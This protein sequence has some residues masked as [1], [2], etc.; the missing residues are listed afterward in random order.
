M[1]DL[2]SRLDLFIKK[3][4]FSLLVKNIIYFSLLTIS[5]ILFFSFIEY[6]FWL[7]SFFRGV[8][9]FATIL[10]LIFIGIIYF[11]LP[12]INISKY[13]KKINRYKAA[14]IIGSFF[15]EI[16]DKFRNTLEL[17]DI[18]DVSR[19]NIDLLDAAVR[20]KS[21]Q[22]YNININSAIQYKGLRNGAIVLLII[23]SAFCMLT[24]S[25]PEVV[26][27]SFNRIIHYN[28]LYIKP[29]PFQ[30]IL[31]NKQL[32]GVQG[33]EET[34]ELTIDGTVLPDQSSIEINGKL[35]PMKKNKEDEF[36]YTISQ[37]KTSFNFRFYAGGYYSQMYFYRV[38]VRPTIV[39]FSVELLYP[40]YTGRINETL[41][42][43]TDYSVP[44]GTK[45]Q[46]SFHGKNVKTLHVFNED[47]LDSSNEISL[48]KNV[49]RYMKTFYN[50]SGIQFNASNDQIMS[51]DTLFCNVE[52][53][54]DA[55]PIIDVLNIVDSTEVTKMY[56]RGKIADDYGFSAL[57][58]CYKS[59]GENEFIKI[60]VP[61]EK[62]AIE[63]EFFFLF[64]FA[65]IEGWRDK[66]VEYYFLVFDN[67]AVNGNKST[68][69]SISA[70]KLPNKE[71]LDE[72]YQK[73]QDQFLNSMNSSMAQI[74]QFQKEMEQMRYDLLNKKEITWE[75]RNK[76]QNLIQKQAE[77]EKQMEEMG[78]ENYEKNKY[79]ELMREMSP[80]M[81]EKQKQ[82]E[83]LFNDIF[84]EEMKALME[85]M[86]EL[87]Q[88]MNKEKMLD[89]IE[90]MQL[91]TEDIEK[92]LQRNMEI[93]KQLEFEK[94][95]NETLDE[96]NQIK[97]QLDS[98]NAQT[99]NS[100]ANQQDLVQKQQQINEAYK[101]VKEE[102]Q[103][104]Q[105]MNEE[106]F[107]PIDFPDA[108]ELMENIEQDLNEAQNNLTKDKKSQASKNQKSGSDQMKE[109]SDKLNN[110]MQ[111][112]E[113]ESLSEDID[114][115]KRILKNLIHISL[116]QEDNITMAK[117]LGPRD[118]RY[119]RVMANQKKIYTRFE[120]VE[121]SLYALSLRQIMIQP[122]IAKD[123]K[124]IKE[125]AAKIDEYLNIGATI[126][127]MTQQQY[128]M[129]STNNLALL[130]IEALD[131]M[132]EMLSKMQM[133]GQGGQC[134]KPKPG[135]SPGKSPTPKTL[136][137]MQEQLNQQMEALMKQ[138]QGG[139]KSGM[140]GSEISEQLAKLA[141]QQ[142]AIRRQL[143]EYAE[144]MRQMGES[145][146]KML[147]Q[148]MQQMEQTERDLV[149][150]QLNQN[151]LNRQ[152]DILVRLMESE[153]AELERE[154]DEKRT[155]RSGKVINNSNPEAYFQY[156][157]KTT[158][159]DEIIKVIPPIF[160]SFYRNKV[161]RFYIELSY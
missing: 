99:Q 10:F 98:L 117:S 109:L 107:N 80:E 86:Q 68:K 139:G 55:Y 143:Q 97:E 23:G 126:P 54:P 152:N 105:K 21:A 13:Y 79:E 30:F 91:R 102:I 122:L 106:L 82:L 44:E 148:I 48:Y 39:N 124:N 14:D 85:K 154:K 157:R 131:Q 45:I 24:F 96:L 111:G 22:F 151:T 41:K 43:I 18:I 158:K 58:F 129:Q 76:M 141:A 116:L 127:A 144:S 142:E 118:Q 95:M 28:K 7:D 135:S 67:D 156:N 62:L 19:E 1:K 89:E 35:Y 104:L 110:A 65:S 132:N 9:F 138:M 77:L 146:L 74:D 53:I 5:I 119:T 61:I 40:S 90:N 57:Y 160:N 32:E 36:L 38:N 94:K 150:K 12:F 17:S 136:R 133:Q 52:V 29:A 69:T 4:H 88:E 121:D 114:N 37:L 20:Q 113:M 84:S 161:N 108:E 25:Y 63:Q 31:E 83:E 51:S 16:A 70:F 11:L 56:T 27:D 8:A 101:K 100:K 115:L 93:L 120:I 103:Q 92:S 134:N 64:D 75:D 49:F 78:E 73:K 145:D 50:S 112:S 153:K 71:E 128:L 60:P 140:S 6:S 66:R 3:Y 34:I 130:L 26:S 72:V 125:Y 59:E 46:W 87:L 81:L 33:D 159:T 15:P 47:S 137:E 155:S 2:L 149:N 42:N 147:N 123:L